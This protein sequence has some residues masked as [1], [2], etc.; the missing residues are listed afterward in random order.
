MNG[1]RLERAAGQVLVGGSEGTSLPGATAARIASGRLGGLVLMGRNVQTP[2][3]VARLLGDALRAAP[4]GLPPP[5]LSVDQEGGRVAR[6]RAGVVQLPPARTLGRGGEPELTRAASRELGRG[7]RALGFSVDFAPVLDLD[8]GPARGI[9]GDRAFSGQ[10]EAAAAHG[11]AAVEGFLDA[12][13]CPCGK[14]FPGHGAT[15]RD[16]HEE[17]PRVR[18]PLDELETHELVPFRAALRSGLPMV[19]TAHVVYEALDP[20]RPA[21]CSRAILD[22]ILRRRLGFDGVVVTDDL[23]MGAVAAVG[24][25]VEVAV[26]ALAAGVDLLLVC[27][28]EDLQEQVLE[29]VAAAARRSGALAGRLEEAAGR[30]LALR[31][32]FRPEP[33]APAD[34]DALLGSVEAIA[35]ARRLEG[36]H[37]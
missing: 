12:G 1:G 9:V 5:L 17:L 10:P 16:S 3:Q 6:L 11:A 32:R 27:H 33:A 23:T 34:L 15:R 14:H 29:G 19:M 24:G 28:R 4:P 26:E 31:T 8:D 25:P 35:L 7:L 20:S 30:V 36:L 21:T 22:G 37:A 2:A 13:I 18:G